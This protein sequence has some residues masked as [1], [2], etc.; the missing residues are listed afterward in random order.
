VLAVA[1]QA[2]MILAVAGQAHLLLA[3]WG[4][5]QE[6]LVGPVAAEP[7]NVVLGKLGVTQPVRGW[8]LPWTIPPGSSPM[9]FLDTLDLRGRKVGAADYETNG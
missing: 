3:V 5:S 4:Q 6:L 2:R 9:A 1:G 8:D 7:D